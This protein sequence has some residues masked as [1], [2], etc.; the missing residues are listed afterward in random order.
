MPRLAVLV[1]GAPSIADLVT[2]ILERL[3]LSVVAASSAAEAVAL[4]TESPDLVV[5]DLAV[6]RAG[7]APIPLCVQASWPR[8]RILALV[9]ATHGRGV[10]GADA[11][12]EK[13][14]LVTTFEATV[15]GLLL[16]P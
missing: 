1:A 16:R 2:R 15:R 5:L 6:D 10:Q 9:T 13:P 4:V 3:G 14:F 12:L 8:T 11:V 7:P